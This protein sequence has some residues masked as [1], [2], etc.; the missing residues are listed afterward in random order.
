MADQS[1][2][3]V[4]RGDHVPGGHTEEND[5]KAQRAEPG[6]DSASHRGHGAHGSHGLGGGGRE[7]HEDPAPPT[8][9]ISKGSDRGGSSGWGGAPSGGSVVDK[10]SPD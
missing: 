9:D 10:R 1:R 2:E 4:P 3:N 6:V 5:A 8:P 7:E